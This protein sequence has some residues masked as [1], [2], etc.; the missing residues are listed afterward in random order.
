MR[1]RARHLLLVLA[2]ACRRGTDPGA[3]PQHGSASAIA[4]VAAA[5]P[6]A[7]AATAKASQPSAAP[8]PQRQAGQ[9]D[10]TRDEVAAVLA[11]DPSHSTSLGSPNNGT[12]VGGVR[13]P[14]RGPGFVHNDKRPDQA[15]FGTVE[16]VQAI[17][18]AAAVVGRELPGSGLTVND[19]GLEH[20]GPIH[21]HG[22]HQ[23][24]RDADILFYMLDQQGAPIPAVGVPLQP[25][26]TGVDFNDLTTDADDVPE[27]IDAPRTWRFVQALL[28]QPGGEQVQRIFL[29]EHLRSILL[30]QAERVRAPA[31]VRQRFSDLTCQP[32]GAP[33][34]D[35]MHVRLFCSAQDI[36]QGCWD[37]PPIYPWH[38]QALHA[39][40]LAPVFEPREARAEHARRAA[41]KAARTT[42]RA[43]A[44]EK[45]GPMRPKVRRF[46]DYRET[47]AKKPHPGRPYCP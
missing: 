1:L 38:R 35:H 18:S 3:A 26:G 33:H 16:L 28:E 31:A 37:K 12:L 34:D 47:W 45:A 24:G 5:Q 8:A 46:L 6:A 4:T 22:S 7:A 2:C 43:Q 20:G 14:D 13:L 17:V 36:A 44:R 23:N 42:T 10:A 29:V 25:D 21:Q 19:L 27:R 30:A 15:R 40:G 11:L 9:A 41:S 32:L 39:L